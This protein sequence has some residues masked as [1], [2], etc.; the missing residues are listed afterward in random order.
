MN[1]PTL[2][3]KAEKPRPDIRKIIKDIIV[4]KQAEVEEWFDDISSKT[5]PFFYNSVDLRNSGFK[6]APVDTNLFPAGFNNLSESERKQAK[7]TTKEFFAKYHKDVKKVLIIAEDHTRNVYYLENIAYLLEII[8]GAGLEVYATNIATSQSGEEVSLKSA[9]GLDV[10]FKPAF[11]EE[12]RIKTRCGFDPEFILVNNDLTDGAPDLL[13]DVEQIVSPP[14]GFGWYRRRKT[15]HFD[16][17]NN[18]ARDFCNKFDIDPWL[19][20]TYFQRCGVVNFKERKGI[21]CVALRVDKT[22]DKIKSKYDEYGIKETPYVFIKSDRGTYGMG[23]MTASSGDEVFEMSKKIRNKMNTI[24]GGVQNTEVIIQ[25]GVPTIDAVEGNPAEPMIYM[26]G[27]KPAGCIYRLNKQKDSY[28]NLNAKGMGF[29]SIANH[30]EDEKV[31]DSLGLI[32]R[33]ASHAAAWE[34]YE[35]IY[36]I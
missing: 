10:N 31:C 8:K 30:T 19:I 3:S 36:S 24:K 26:I 27:A 13:K 25:E 1:N 21:E 6:L 2:A 7:Q 33:I 5:P 34:C 9:S 22:I 18:M 32:S 28:G 15:S 14:L 29:A 23:I 20:T 4:N 16:T 17:Y 35:E 12:G 11:K